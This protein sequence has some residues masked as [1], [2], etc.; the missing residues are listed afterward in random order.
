MYMVGTTAKAIGTHSGATQAN[1]GSW[2]QLY[3]A[4][5]SY[6]PSRRQIYI[7]A[8]QS[9]AVIGWSYSSMFTCIS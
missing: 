9:R 6:I 4:L 8:L 7:R 1:T 2:Q 5:A 3:F